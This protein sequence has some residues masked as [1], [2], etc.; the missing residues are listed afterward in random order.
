MTRS[1]R[2][3]IIR[4]VAIRLT[5]AAC[6]L[7]APLAGASAIDSGTDYGA[8]LTMHDVSDLSSVLANAEAHTERPVLVRG[9]ISDVCQK[10]G[11]WTVIAAGADTVRVRFA[12]YGFFLPKD[13]SGKTAYVEGV[14]TI[15]TLSEKDARHYFK[16]SKA[17]NESKAAKS[18][19]SEDS[20]GIHG[21][22]REVG[23][24]ATGVRLVD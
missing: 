22:Q 21:P 3:K 7:L 13:S 12:D 23:F 9:R 6:A 4:R 15:R 20:S 11:C 18:Q 5:V 1:T 10:K 8:G 17:F 2:A 14:V 24:L 16:E 19:A